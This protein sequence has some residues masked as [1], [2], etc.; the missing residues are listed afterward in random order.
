MILKKTT[1]VG[2]LLA[3][4]EA[5]G[6][7]E[8]PASVQ[9]KSGPSFSLTGRDD[10]LIVFA[11]LNGQKSHVPGTNVFSVVW[12]VQGGFLLCAVTDS[13]GRTFFNRLRRRSKYD[14]R[15]NTMIRRKGSA[16]WVSALLL[17]S[18][19]C[20]RPEIPTVVKVGSGP[21]FALTGSGR[22]ASFTVY[23]PMSGQK[24]A[25]EPGDVSSIVWQISSSNGYFQGAPVGGLHLIYGRA[26]EGY[27]QIAPDRSQ[28]PP[29]LSPGLIYAFF[30]E[31]T[32]AGI[33]SGSF[34]VGKSG[35]AFSVA[36]DLCVTLENGRHLRVDCKTREP[37][38]E[39]AD[40][41]KFA[42]E[43]RSK[44]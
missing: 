24:V 27:N 39:P 17:M 37:Y 32:G 34:Y 44:E 23:A 31:S 12:Q 6:P 2:D 20:E 29:P 7:P 14:W 9:V 15:D 26:P 13:G 4:L 21:S 5:C 16:F 3:L 38:R 1:A 40:I 25:S 10:W 8:I 30:A 43:H 11:P 36:T 22:L 35:T 19:A 18:A 41:E 28:A 33:A 42:E